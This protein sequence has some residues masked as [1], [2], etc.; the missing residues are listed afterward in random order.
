M[1][2]EKSASNATLDAVS[3][4][5]IETNGLRMHIAE[6]GTGPLVLLCH[7][8]P[9]LW[10][11]WRYQ[12][13][14]LSEAGYHVVAPDLRGYG[15]TDQPDDVE[16]YTLLH[17]VG[18]LIGVLDVLGE[19]RAILVGHDWGA[20][21]AWHA[22]LLRPDRFP[23]LICMSAPYIP[24]GP[25]H[26]KRAT[27]PPTQAWKQAWGDQSFYQSYFQQPGVAEAEVERDVRTTMRRLL[28]GLS[29][30]APSSERW[31]PILPDPQAGA[32][33]SAG[34]PTTLP[35]WLTEAD[36]DMYTAEFGR[37][38]FRGGLNWYRN[39]DRN[40]ELLAPYSGASVTQPTLFLW[41][42][43]DPTFEVAGMSKW[44]ER[45]P[46]FVPNLHQVSFQGCGHWIQ[47]ERASEVNAAILAFLQQEGL[48]PSSTI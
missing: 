29:G 47:Q 10:N 20:A 8:F 1:T 4:Q 39:I 27:L 9:E 30:D 33:N 13:P 6:Q 40:W 15:Q 35:S 11:A 16:V 45:M 36:I 34:N 2:S 3:H 42:D 44:V 24:R 19:Q 43:R 41:G 28:Y 25:L 14:A 31:H 37:T 23:V 22:A 38:G 5:F 48:H 21:L 32:L 17:L 26:G 7:G 46:Q 18:D 12:F